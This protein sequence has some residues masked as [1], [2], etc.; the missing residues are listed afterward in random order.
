MPLEPQWGRSPRWGLCAGLAERRSCLAT[1][2]VPLRRVALIPPQV[3]LH[4]ADLTLY[5]LRFVSAAALDD[6]PW[7]TFSQAQASYTVTGKQA[8]HT[9]IS[10]E[11]WLGAAES[12][13]LARCRCSVELS[14][15][16]HLL[17]SRLACAL[18]SEHQ[19]G[20]SHCQSCHMQPSPASAC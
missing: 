9:P 6:R 8:V 2:L 3:V 17:T 19:A 18:F 12:L 5:K 4:N 7:L 13:S 1:C 11:G 15:R 20:L 10:R 16:Q 14:L